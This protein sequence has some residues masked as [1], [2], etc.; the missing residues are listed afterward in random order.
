MGIKC[1]QCNREF[2]DSKSLSQHARAKHQSEEEVSHKVLRRKE[3]K[4]IRKQEKAALRSSASRN[5]VLKYGLVVIVLIVIGYGIY[6]YT[7]GGTTLSGN[8]VSSDLIPSTPI[9]WHP[10]LTI[11]INEQLQIIPPD[12]GSIAGRHQP[13]HTHGEDN[14]QGVMHWELSSPT[15]ETMR[16]GYFFRI[17]GKD[18]NSEC[19]FD[20]CNNA[21]NSVKMFVNGQPNFDFENYII[22]DN[23]RIEIEYSPRKSEVPVIEE[24]DVKEFRLYAPHQGYTFTPK[25]LKVKKGDKVR[26]VATSN[27]L[28]HRHGVTIDE[29]GINEAIL[30]ADTNNPKI[31]EFTANKT[32]SFRIWCKTCLSGAFGAHSWM[33]ATLIVE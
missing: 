6:S 10:Q 3:L 20:Y 22:Q 33:Q 13:I 19:I 4:D 24:S 28:N 5:K 18:F 16:L 26:F 23:D 9:H 7:D 8:I 2:I 21:E 30:T 11:K 14:L 25:E 27:L 32:G 15:I 1:N 29:F 31:I 12:V 17:W